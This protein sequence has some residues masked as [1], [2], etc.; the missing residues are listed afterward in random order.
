M[1][2]KFAI[3]D[4]IED[5]EF[6]NLSPATIITYQNTFRNFKEWCGE[7]E[8]IDVTEITERTIKKYLLYCKKER[9]NKPTSINHKIR[10]LRMLFNYMEETGII[11]KDKNP[12]TKIKT[13]KEDVKIEVFSDYHIRQMLNYYRR[14]RT[15]DKTFWAYRDYTMIVVLYGTG[16]R[17]GEL[18]SLE[19]RNVDLINKNITVFGKKRIQR[20]IPVVE[21]LSKELAEYRI[22]CERYFNKLGKFVFVDN[23]NIKLSKNAIQNIF[24]RLKKIMNFRDVRLSCHTFRHTFAHR[25]LT[26][27]CDIFTLQK[28]LG[29]STLDMTK[30]Y[31]ALWGTALKDQNEKYNPLNRFEF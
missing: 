24:K 21:K 13:I 28:M 27:G 3:Q 14:I 22:F 9:E 11:K 30:K 19:W 26:A 15:R 10:N 25:M 1:L 31:L 29:H 4:F 8:I 6:K 20:S 5:R 23:E 18:A 2:L 17:L 12:M 7:N 16:I